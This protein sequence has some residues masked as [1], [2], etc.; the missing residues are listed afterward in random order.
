MSQVSECIFNRFILVLYVINS[1]NKD[2][3]QISRHRMQMGD[4]G[5]NK[6]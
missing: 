1:I 2:T 6:Y 3:M 5:L 4:I